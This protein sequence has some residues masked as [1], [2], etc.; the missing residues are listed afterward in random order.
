MVNG[1]IIEST[2]VI[3][4]SG[5][6]DSS[7]SLQVE[8]EVF[9]LINENKPNKI[10][11]EAKDLEYISSAGLRVLL[12]VIKS[13]EEKIVMRNVNST[14]GDIL[15]VTGFNTLMKVERAL[16]EVSI[17]GC[18]IIGKGASA[19]VYRLDE[20]T[21]IKVYTDR[22][23]FEEIEKERKLAQAAFL[24]G[25]PTAITYDIVKVNDNYGIIFELIKAKTLSSLIAQDPIKYGTIFGKLLKQIHT[26]KVDTNKITSIKDTYKWYIDEISSR[27]TKE[28]E[29]KFKDF[30]DSI[31]DRGTMIHGDYHTSNVMLQND[32]PILIDMG[33][34]GY[35]HPI[36]DLGGVY[37]A[38]VLA[39]KMRPE[40][41]MQYHGLS[42][43]DALKAYDGFIKGYF[44]IEDKDKIEQIN[45]V[46]GS[47]A[48][49]KAL[50][51]I[52]QGKDL[53]EEVKT[54]LVEDLRKHFFPIMDQIGDELT[55]LDI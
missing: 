55:S 44:E 15:H 42:P 18:K 50:M 4:L 24:L 39:A 16:R 20:D 38:L 28:E 46:L 32:E 30:I 40:I 54:G 5:R 14:V 21:I 13:T 49:L 33:D 29:T 35:G 1:E 6:V 7:T 48:M 43:D 34:I 8:K 3:N 17:D 37:S 22:T 2:L 52:V 41:L 27:I 31:P 9:D 53:P 11:F 47:Y 25:V 10:I 51:G 26:T 12:K 19:T 45:K 36:F 23:S